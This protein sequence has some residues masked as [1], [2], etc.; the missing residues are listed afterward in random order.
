MLGVFYF[1][2]K[3]G[4]HFVTNKVRR[5][6]H[7]SGHLGDMRCDASRNLAEFADTDT[8]VNDAKYGQMPPSTVVPFNV[9][10]LSRNVR[11]AVELTFRLICI[12]FPPSCALADI[13]FTL[14]DILQQKVH[15][16]CS[17]S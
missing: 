11:G 17:A 14:T 7:N 12:H 9:V 1:S 13:S 3:R 5:F 2:E 6:G 4:Y 16:D 15:L 10:A 8:P